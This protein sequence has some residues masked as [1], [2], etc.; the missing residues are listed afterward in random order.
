MGAARPKKKIADALKKKGF[1]ADSG[2]DHVVFR[3]VHDGRGTAVRTRVSHSK[4]VKDIGDNMRDVI[5][6]T[7]QNYPMYAEWFKDEK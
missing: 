1:E 6:R 3:F 2:K 4:K 5:T 7:A